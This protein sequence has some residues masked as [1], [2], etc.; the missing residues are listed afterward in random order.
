MCN[1]LIVGDAPVVPDVACSLTGSSPSW[2]IRTASGELFD[3]AK[4]IAPDVLLLVLDRLF[5]EGNTTV[6]RIRQSGYAGP[7]LVL[8]QAATARERALVLAL[9]ADDCMTAPL[10][11]LELI[12]RVDAL[13]R[14]GA[15][16]ESPAPSE[17]TFG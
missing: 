4:P 10:D 8:V 7:I 13:I 15:G 14:R 5:P 9:G 16:R 11:A 12:S 17:L 3:T 2:T 6:T 1:I